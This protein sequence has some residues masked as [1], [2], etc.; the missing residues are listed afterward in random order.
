MLRLSIN[1]LKSNVYKYSEKYT[2]TV[3]D[4]DRRSE[5]SDQGVLSSLP[6]VVAT[7]FGNCTTSL[8]ISYNPVSSL[9]SLSVLFYLAE[10]VAD[11]CLL[12]SPIRIPELPF[13]RVRESQLA[14]HAFPLSCTFKLYPR[15]PGRIRG[16][17]ILA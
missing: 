13:L 11:N 7:A 14:Q 8:D 15:T 6:S 5:I 3:F 16:E 4:S 1:K 2:I 9:E 17:S 10:L 12:S